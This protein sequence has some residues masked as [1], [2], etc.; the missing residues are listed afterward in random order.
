MNYF[1]RKNVGVHYCTGLVLAILCALSL[2]SG[3]R[4]QSCIDDFEEI[5]KREA[6][7]TDTTF[8]R[9]YI[10]CPRTIYDIGY[11]DFSGNLIRPSIGRISPPIPLRSNMTI[12]CGDQGSRENQCW[13]NGGDLHMDG[14]NIYG[15]KD[16]I[17]ENVRIEGIS[18]I[19]A[20]DHSLW[21][22]KPG[23]ITFRDCQFRGF[24]NSSV[25]IMLDYYD[26]S[27]P[28]RELVT[29]FDD[30]EFRVSWLECLVLGF[31]ERIFVDWI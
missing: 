3:T 17:L 4:G 31:H 9:M 21:A 19:G 14:T 26:A 22:T 15:I 6:V 25:P 28:S 27:N 7:V 10:L 8:P 20:R 5:Y 1:T 18:F 11:L 16:D 24:T 30:C 23:S 12:R 2:P 29:T 13:L